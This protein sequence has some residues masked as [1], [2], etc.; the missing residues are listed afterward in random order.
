MQA[1]IAKQ[2]GINQGY[3]SEL[4]NLSKAGSRDT[5]ARLAEELHVPKAWLI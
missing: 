5:L 2:V 3:L 1:E 4:E